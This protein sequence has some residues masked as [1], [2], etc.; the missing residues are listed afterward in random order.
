MTLSALVRAWKNRFAATPTTKDRDPAG[1][2]LSAE[3]VTGPAHG[4]LTLNADGS[5]CYTP[6]RD[7][8]GSDRFTYRATN[9]LNASDA[10]EVTITVSERGPEIAN[11]ITP[12]LTRRTH[13]DIRTTTPPP[14]AAPA[15]VAANPDPVP[16]VARDPAAAL[17][18]Q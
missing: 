3:L 11:E 1:R 7:F 17:I 4:N 15:T 16:V 10:T 14:A 6:H 18:S 2:P 8:N 9:G 12:V 13:G 5:F